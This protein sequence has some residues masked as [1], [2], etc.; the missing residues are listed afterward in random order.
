MPSLTQSHSCIHTQVHVT[1]L[2]LFPNPPPQTCTLHPQHNIS[3]ISYGTIFCRRL[4]TDIGRKSGCPKKCT[5]FVSL[6]VSIRFCA[7]CSNIGTSKDSQIHGYLLTPPPDSVTR[8]WRSR[9]HVLEVSTVLG[10]AQRCS[11]SGLLGHLSTCGGG[12]SPDGSTNS[13][14][15]GT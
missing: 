2:P 4:Q 13:L 10:H 8:L 12:N 9:C 7:T 11:A 6:I 5:T 3:P 14:F 1:P 15:Q